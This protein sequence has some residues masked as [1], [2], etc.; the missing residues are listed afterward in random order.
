MRRRWRWRLGLES[1]SLCRGED[2]GL[3]VVLRLR[4]AVSNFETESSDI[5]SSSVSEFTVDV[6]SWGKIKVGRVGMDTGNV[7][8]DDRLRWGN[9]GEMGDDW[10]VLRRKKVEMGV[11][12]M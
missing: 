8:L 3:R 12:A 5:I 7:G 6:T 1:D 10:G 11:F 4:A 9:V 2:R